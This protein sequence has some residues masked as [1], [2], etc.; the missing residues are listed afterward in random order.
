M[1][2]PNPVRL[3]W[4]RRLLLIGILPAVLALLFA[5]KVEVMISVQASGEAAYGT[6]D[7]AGAAEKFAANATLNILEPWLSPFNE[8]AAKQRS[9]DHEGALMDY[10]RALDDVPDEQECTVRI[11]MALAHEVL[12]DTVLPESDATTAMTSWQSGRDLLAAGECPSDAAG[13]QRQ[14]QYAADVDER[15]RQKIDEQDAAGPDEP[16]KKDTTKQESDSEKRKKQKE[17][18]EKR[19]TDGFEKRQENKEFEDYQDAPRSPQY[20]W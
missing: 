16:K 12:G 6:D 18:L 10:R 19:N 9:E 15:L 4:R 20:H 2:S 8:G 14:T 1:K 13:G 11:N 3:R 7:F 17:E 5:S